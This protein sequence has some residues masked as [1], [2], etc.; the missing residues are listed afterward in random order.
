MIKQKRRSRRIIKRERRFFSKALG[1]KTDFELKLYLLK[2]ASMRLAD[3][4]P[5]A[6]PVPGYVVQ[7]DD[8]ANILIDSGFPADAIENP[9]RYAPPKMLVEMREEDYVVNRLNSIGLRPA[10]IDVLICT[11]FDP[12]HAGNHDLF[13]RA[14]LVVQRTAYECALSSNHKRF[15]SI[16]RHWNHSSLRYRF[17]EGDAELVPGVELVETSGH[18]PGHQSVLI[19]LSETGTVI[20]AIDAIPHSSMLEADTRRI[21][22]LDM[23]EAGTR[24]G[25]RKLVELAK[26]ERAALIVHGHDARQW[27]TLKR[28]PEFYE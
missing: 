9:Q 25:T 7:T 13:S 8:G 4:P 12:D 24:A 14:E 6:I 19:R 22:S 27:A 21:L 17:V 15:T 11:H 16:R 23:D 5:T 2:L 18:V 28:A 10:D 3:A 26:R 1:L 20:L